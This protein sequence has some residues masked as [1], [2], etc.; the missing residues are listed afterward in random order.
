M[1]V[2]LTV[3]PPVLTINQ[4]V[5]FMVTDLNGEISSETEQGIYCG[6]TR[7]V[8]HYRI[9]ASDV[10][11]TRITSSN[12]AY[13]AARIYLTNQKLVTEFGEIPAA[14]LSFVFSRA[15][16]RFGIVQRIEVTNHNLF[17]VKFN[18]EIEARSD[19]ADLFE[20]KNQSYVHRS[21]IE[22]KWDLAQGLG[23]IQYE[24]GEFRRVLRV[25]PLSTTRPKFANGRLRYEIALQ[26]GETWHSTHR[27]DLDIGQSSEEAP[28]AQGKLTEA[29]IAQFQKDWRQRATSL[30]ST[31]TDLHQAFDQSVE[32][33][34]ALRL[35]FYQLGPDVWVP[36]AGVPWFVTLFGRDSLVVSLQNMIVHPGFARGALEMLAKFQ[37][38]DRDDWRDAQP[39]KILHELRVDE[40][41]CQGKLPFSPYYGTWD[42]TTFYLIVLHEAWKW[43]G[44]D[45][46]LRQFRGT[47]EKCLEWVDQYGDLDGDGFQE[48]KTFSTRG[49]ENMGWKDA[50]DAVVYPDGSQV[51]QPKALCELQGYVYD[52]WLRMAEVFDVL[53]EPQTADRLRLKAA[54]LQKRF[55]AQFWCEDIGFYAYGLDPDKKPIKSIASNP[56]HCLWSGIAAPEHAAMVVKR[57]FEP[58]MWSGWGIRTISSKNPAY[59]PFSYQL[60]SVWPHDNGIIAMGFKRYGFS[61]EAAR[62]AKDVIDA[63]SYFVSYRLPELY[64]GIARDPLNFPVQYLGANVPQAWA[65]GCIFQF[66]QAMLGVQADAP[67]KRLTIDPSLP[68]WL[69]DV[70]LRGLKVG[71][72]VVDVR[73]WR[74]GDQTRWDVL[75]ND[76]GLTIEQ[77][78]WEPGMGATPPGIGK[79]AA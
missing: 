79:K 1:P 4:D 63:S 44:D 62:V 15:A 34:G 76:S 73:F 46:M 53:G 28:A 56:G 54:N 47:A 5:T 66:V 11:L 77:K 39:G 30:D 27:L 38:T 12:V 65:A 17:P 51:K 18:L 59:N 26:P 29:D 23:V 6:D 3:G 67:H 60:G 20:V 31:Q 24:N 61:A 48:Y 55:E 45:S 8:N 37:A 13:N 58:D 68:E 2:K 42:A 69:P 10:P 9:F 78:A 43:L 70:T 36:A 14:T 16:I 50:G 19:F 35:Y 71:Q 7:F 64:A 33:M 57:F 74:E 22:S 21:N 75:A 49:Y 72:G 41:T 32:D 25:S 40:Q 52:A